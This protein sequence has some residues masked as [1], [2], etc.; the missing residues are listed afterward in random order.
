[1]CV[2]ELLLRTIGIPLPATYLPLCSPLFPCLWQ[3]V[4]N[5]PG[6]ASAGA[7]PS[8]SQALRVLRVFVVN[9][10]LPPPLKICAIKVEFCGTFGV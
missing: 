7:C 2:V 5:L 4:V 6:K 8:A 3:K 1:M 10:D 9:Q